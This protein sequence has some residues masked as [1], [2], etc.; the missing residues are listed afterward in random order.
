MEKPNLVSILITCHVIK[1]LNRKMHNIVANKILEKITEFYQ[2]ILFFAEVISKKLDFLGTFSR[3]TA[4]KT[5]F[6]IFEFKKNIL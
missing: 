1:I 6:K 2:K 3:K 4:K 5:A